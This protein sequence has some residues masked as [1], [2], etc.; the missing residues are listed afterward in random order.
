SFAAGAMIATC[1]S[2]L[3]PQASNDNKNF[4]TLLFTLG[5]IIMMILDVALG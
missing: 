4:S 3:I 1:V 2:E 5:F